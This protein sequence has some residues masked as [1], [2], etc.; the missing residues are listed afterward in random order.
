MLAKQKIRISDGVIN[1]FIGLLETVRDSQFKIGDRLIE[2]VE[3]HGDRAGVINALAGNLNL[4][5]SVLY[6]YY[7]T[8][9]RWTRGFREVW[10]N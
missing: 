2:L 8:S 7:R 6:D 3:Q 9:K 5:A 1:E 10:Q 4:S